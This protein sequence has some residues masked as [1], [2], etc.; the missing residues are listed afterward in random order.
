MN[1]Q[2]C[3]TPTK[4][5]TGFWDGECGTFGQL[6]DCQ[7]LNCKTKQDKIKDAES[8][9]EKRQAVVKAN[10]R[11]EVQMIS[12]RS[13]R[14]ELQITISKMAKSLGISPSDYSNYEQCRVALPVE[15]AERIEGMFRDNEVRAIMNPSVEGDPV[16]PEKLIKTMRRVGKEALDK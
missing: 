13:K 15:M 8:E 11:N 16:L 6:F 2:T 9:E 7:N 4:Y 5:T 1:C 14:K 12:I 10:A 3:A